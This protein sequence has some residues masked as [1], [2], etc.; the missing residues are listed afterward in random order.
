MQQ[1]HDRTLLLPATTKKKVMF[2]ND[3]H[4]SCFVGQL[5]FYLWKL[6]LLVTSIVQLVAIQNQ[7]K[8]CAAAFGE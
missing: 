4:I 3:F 6:F 7:K 8:L 5:L 1:L 2:L